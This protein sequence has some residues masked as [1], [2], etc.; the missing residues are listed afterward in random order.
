M[1][2]DLLFQ[3]RHADSLQNPHRGQSSQVSS[4]HQDLCKRILPSSAS[5][6]T[7]GHQTLPLL[8]LREMFSPALSLATA[9]QVCGFFSFLHRPHLYTYRTSCP[10]VEQLLI[11]FPASKQIL[12]VIVPE[13][14]RVTGLT[15]VPIQDVKKLSPNCLI[16]RYREKTVT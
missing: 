5:A 8:L 14:T 12:F 6:H 13:S 2:A 3:V 15:S 16:C 1:S 9:Y 10:K 11:L 4:L 7:P